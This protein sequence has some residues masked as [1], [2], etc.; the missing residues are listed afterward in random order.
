MAKMNMDFEK[1]ILIN[2]N[3]DAVLH[4]IRASDLI[5]N[6]PD[7]TGTKHYIGDMKWFVCVCVCVCYKSACR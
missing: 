5:N 3:Y 7:A 1:E 4:I 2:K 6:I